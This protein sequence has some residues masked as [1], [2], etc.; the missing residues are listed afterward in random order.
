[1]RNAVAIHRDS[2]EVKMEIIR[3]RWGKIQLLDV[4]FSCAHSVYL[5][6]LS[7]IQFFNKKFLLCIRV[8]FETTNVLFLAEKIH[9]NHTFCTH[10]TTIAMKKK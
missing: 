8:A 5:P 3:L 9:A 7:A 4:S 2:K 6:F 10:K 1:M